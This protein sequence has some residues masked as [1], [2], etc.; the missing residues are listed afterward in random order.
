MKQTYPKKVSLINANEIDVI[1]LCKQYIRI[2]GIVCMILFFVVGILHF[3]Q[4]KTWFMQRK[5]I[6]F[7]HKKIM[8][9]QVALA[10]YQKMCE[11]K[12]QLAIYQK[13]IMHYKNHKNIP[14][15]MFSMLKTIATDA[16]SFSQLHIKKKN[17]E[18]TVYASDLY[19]INNF[20]KKI[21]EAKN[22]KKIVISSLHHDLEKKQ[23]YC[24]L[25]A[26]IIQ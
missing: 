17:F 1:L 14:I 4:A 19:E 5:K 2:F 23:Y 6:N 12:E 11:K 7:L 10:Q 9:S 8:Q 13:K 15:K 3:K 16:I 22:S 25:Q 26:K 20:L 24:C 18:T 21:A